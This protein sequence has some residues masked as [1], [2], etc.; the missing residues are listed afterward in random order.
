MAQ[1]GDPELDTAATGLPGAFAASSASAMVAA[2]IVNFLTSLVGRTSPVSGST[3]VATPQGAPLTEPHHFQAP[4][5]RMTLPTR[6]DCFT[7]PYDAYQQGAEFRMPASRRCLKAVLISICGAQPSQ[8]MN[9]ASSGRPVG[10][11]TLSQRPC[12]KVGL[13][14][15]WSGIQVAAPRRR[16]GST[17]AESVDV[18]LAA[19]S[20]PCEPSTEPGQEPLARTAISRRCCADLG[21][22]RSIAARSNR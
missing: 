7:W 2:F 20:A 12:P 9:V 17:S 11:S 6:R 14:H 16:A 21:S 10:P 13:L 1:L 15:P 3:T 8:Y 4:H 18:S 5:P 19:M 22:C